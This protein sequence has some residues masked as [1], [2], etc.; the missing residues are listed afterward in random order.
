MISACMQFYELRIKNKQY[1]GKLAKKLCKFVL[2]KLGV[3]KADL[4]NP[5]SLEILLQEVKEHKPVQAQ[6]MERYSQT[7]AFL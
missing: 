5:G 7:N 4:K 2:Q 6:F 1:Q 3:D